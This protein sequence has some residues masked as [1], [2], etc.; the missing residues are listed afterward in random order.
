MI[1]SQ[2]KWKDKIEQIVKKQDL[3]IQVLLKKLETSFSFGKDYLKVNVIF[4]D[5]NWKR[6]E[7]RIN[8][9]NRNWI[10]FEEKKDI[11]TLWFNTSIF[12]DLMEENLNI[13]VLKFPKI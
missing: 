9:H 3:L 12:W 4:P 10:N 5:T 11:K 2:E 1:M 7:E 8:F 6:N 13:Y